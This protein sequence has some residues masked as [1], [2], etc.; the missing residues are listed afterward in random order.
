MPV[1]H[2]RALIGRSVYC[3][4]S[5]MLRP[6]AGILERVIIDVAI[7]QT[8]RAC[9]GVRAHHITELRANGGHYSAS[10]MGGRGLKTASTL[11]EQ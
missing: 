10:A 4:A 3:N 9:Y 1:E 8:E 6:I 2:I 5:W 7:I 11:G